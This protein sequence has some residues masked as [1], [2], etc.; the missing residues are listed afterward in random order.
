MPEGDPKDLPEPPK[1]ETG[2][3]IGKPDQVLHMRD[4]PFK[5]QAQGT[6]DYQRFVVDP[7]WEED[8]YICAAEAR[9]DNKSVVHHILVYVLSPDGEQ[10]GGLGRPVLVGYA[11]GSVPVELKDGIAMKVP[12]GS[13]LLFEM[14]Y[15]PNGY[16][17][18]DRSYAG[19]KFMEKDE[20]TKLIKGKAVVTNRFRIPP[21]DDH[22]EVTESY[23]SSRDELLVSMTPHMHLR[24]KAFKYEATYPDGEK[25]VL[26]DVPKYDFNWQLKYILDQPKLLPRGTTIKCTAVYDNSEENLSNPDPTR[27]VGW[28]DQS[29]EEMMIGFFDTLPP[30]HGSSGKST[31]KSN[32][33]IDP[34]GKY[35]WKGFSPGKLT[36]NLA[37]D[38]LTGTLVSRGREYEIQ[39]AVIDGKELHF[40]VDGGE[41]YLEFDAKVSDDALVG[42]CNFQLDSLGKGRS[43]PW[44]A[45]KRD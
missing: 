2:W 42:K 35:S 19:V 22:H 23:R 38:V 9:P 5:V 18:E 32:A 43:F 29:W 41:F 3:R 37:D 13:K 16:E 36:L 15:T 20:V 33:S 4:R 28:G 34:S 24:G 7:G 31:K 17:S 11:P 40:A 8:K 6:I 14:H 10:R 25:E 26:L 1:F 39:D 45:A 27:S 21:H 30:D 44:S 12:A